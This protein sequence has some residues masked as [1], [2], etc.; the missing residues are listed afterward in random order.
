MCVAC[1]DLSLCSGKALTVLSSAPQGL[2]GPPGDKGENG[3]VGAMV[4]AAATFIFSAF[5]CC[6]VAAVVAESPSEYAIMKLN[7]RDLVLHFSLRST[8]SE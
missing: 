8:F 1:A 3:D 4:S 2:P 6:A 7:T 5:K